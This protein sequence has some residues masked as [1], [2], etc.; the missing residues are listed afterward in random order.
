MCIGAVVGAALRQHTI[1]KRTLMRLGVASQLVVIVDDSVTNL[2][3]LERLALSLD[4]QTV[5]ESFTDP[6]RALAFCASRPPDLV[7]L[8][9]AGGHGA[10]AETIARLRGLADG[11][12][13][14]VI[15]VGSQP[16]LDAIERAC[17]AGAADHLLIPVDAREFRIRAGRLLRRRVVP[18][19]A[20]ERGDAGGD[21]RP[22]PA[23]ARHAY[24][25][26]LRLIDVIPRMIC[27]TAHD[28][29]YLL[30]N[31]MFASFVGLPAS[32]LA[33]KRPADAHGGLL[34]RILMD[35]DERLLTGRAVQAPSEDEIVDRNGNPC[36]LL[37]TKALFDAGDSGEAMVVTVFVDITERKRAERDLTAAKEQAELANRSKT[38]FVANMSHELRTPLNAIIGF[39][40][41]I[42]GEMLGPIGTAKYV[43]YAR[44]I[45]TSAEHLLGLINDILDVSKLEAGK[46][47]LAEEVIDPAKTI[48]DLAQLAEAK[49]RTSD[50]RV[51]IRREGVI[52]LL[53]ADVRKLK[54]IILNLLVN[55]IKFSHAGG[56]VEIVLRNVGGAVAIA[57]VDHGIGM[58]AAEVQLAMTRFGQVASA[59]TRKHDGTG[60]GLPLA[61]GLTELH[62]GTL[63]IVS[64]KGI[65][66]TVTVTFPRERSQPLPQAA[67]GGIRVVG[68]S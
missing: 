31:R 32:R 50:V 44:D 53:L 16:D 1:V 41:V 51:S 38:E 52:P 10:A 28:G 12:A 27:V 58:D 60:L 42:A 22:F 26:L 54:Q 46:L 13:V 61:I 45:L 36:V 2:K 64:T 6:G 11:A 24:E 66:T 43:G 21:D 63:T 47:D 9:A 48:A 35:G 56:K 25:T 18:A 57:V 5:V 67:T 55:A 34:A 23:G 29:R 40:Q 14:P 59:W 3:I 19:G 17:E 39:S 62:G 20:E 37:T 68:Q 65:G 30:V 8:A 4:G 15:V 7:L 49:A 33:G